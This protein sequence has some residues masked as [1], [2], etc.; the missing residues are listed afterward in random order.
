LKRGPLPAE[1]ALSIAKQN[2]RHVAR[3]FSAR[4]KARDYGIPQGRRITEQ[5]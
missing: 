3:F 4:H 5:E 1:E 2:M